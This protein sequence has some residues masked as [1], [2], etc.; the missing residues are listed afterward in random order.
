[1]NLDL[2]GI[3]PVLQQNGSELDLDVINDAIASFVSVNM[4]NTHIK[5][6]HVSNGLIVQE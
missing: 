6:M 4:F 5:Q 2:L 1:M 3:L